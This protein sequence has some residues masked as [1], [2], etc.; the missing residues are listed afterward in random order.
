MCNKMTTQQEATRHKH[1][2]YVLNMHTAGLFLPAS[3][4]KSLRREAAEKLLAI[5]QA[6]NR[7]DA[8][9]QSEILPSLLAAAAGLPLPAH[10]IRPGLTGH[11]PDLDEAEAAPSP[12]SRSTSSGSRR[13]PGSDA[14]A[15]S[16]GLRVLCRSR[17]QVEAACAVP[18]LQE[19]ILDFLEVQ[20]IKEAVVFARMSR[21]R[22]SEK[23]HSFSWRH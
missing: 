22:V 7:A 17:A 9:S 23:S 12:R 1:C 2:S 3:E 18:W 5:R 15:A 13:A 8:L 14:L 10:A 19:V 6:H 20:G 11:I 21:K 4:F 16:A